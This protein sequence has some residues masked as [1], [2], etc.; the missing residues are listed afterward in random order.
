MIRIDICTDNDAF[1]P[2]SGPE[3]IRILQEQV[4]RP[5]AQGTRQGPWSL[6]DANGNTVGTIDYAQK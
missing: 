2:E 4:I 1:Q 3:I 5:I 6:R